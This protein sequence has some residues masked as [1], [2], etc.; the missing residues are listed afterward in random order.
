MHHQRLKLENSSIL[1]PGQT[2][3]LSIHKM[4][5]TLRRID[6]LCVSH[7]ELHHLSTPLSHL[8]YV[9]VLCTE[10]VSAGIRSV[11]VCVCAHAHVCV[12]VHT[13][14]CVCTHTHVCVKEREREDNSVCAHV[15]IHIYMCMCRMHV[16]VAL[17]MT[18]HE[19]V[20]SHSV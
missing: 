18:D 17:C 14:V 6:V 20:H 16:G 5:I 8:L 13:C 2:G 12:C 9:N 10:Y 3:L 19:C 11:L 1:H 15:H 7:S 4:Y